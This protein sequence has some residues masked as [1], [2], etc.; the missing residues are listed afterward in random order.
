MIHEIG[1]IVREDKDP[2][3]I[4]RALAQGAGG[5]IV[6]GAVPADVLEEGAHYRDRPGAGIPMIVADEQAPD[7]CRWE[8]SDGALPLT[9]SWLMEEFKWAASA[10]LCRKPEQAQGRNKLLRLWANEAQHLPWHID[11]GISEIYPDIHIHLAGHGMKIATP[12]QTMEMTFSN[13]AVSPNLQ[14]PG[15]SIYKIPYKNADQ[16]VHKKLNEYLRERGVPVCQM[17]PGE[18]LFFNDKCLHVSAGRK[19]QRLRAAIF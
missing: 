4:R 5:V 6:A 7:H 1:P 18:M 11:L 17:Q 16:I 8:A 15:V 13:V 12:A 19:K 2:V 9:R 3:K 10:G 14:A